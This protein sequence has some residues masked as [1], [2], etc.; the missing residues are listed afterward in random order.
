MTNSKAERPKM[1]PLICFVFMKISTPDLKY[2]FM[3]MTNC[4]KLS[5]TNKLNYIY[6][7]D[8]Y[9]CNRLTNKLEKGSQHFIPDCQKWGKSILLK[10]F[11]NYVK[12]YLLKCT[13]EKSHHK[14]SP[15]GLIWWSNNWFHF[16]H[17]AFPRKNYK[18]YK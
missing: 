18:K 13:I 10:L 8:W 7:I 1:V 3:V 5:T 4:I 12:S 16:I 11:R 17:R 2:I 14:K 9:F 6:E 15:N